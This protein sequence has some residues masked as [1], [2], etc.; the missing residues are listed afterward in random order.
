MKKV[1]FAFITVASLTACSNSANEK[2]EAVDSTAEQKKEAIDST[3]D[4][5]KEGMDKVDSAG[6]AMDSATKK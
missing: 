3:A 5:M 4:K 6:K 1:F 2:K